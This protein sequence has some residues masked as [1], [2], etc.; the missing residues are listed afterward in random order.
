MLSLFASAAH[1]TILRALADGPVNLAALRGRAGIPSEAA[2]WG[3]IGNLI[4]IG[5]VE[6]RPPD[7]RPDLLDNELTPLGRELLSV[8]SAVDDWL[9]RGPAGPLEAESEP[10]R[11]AVKALVAGW[12]SSM[13]RALAARPLSLA[14]L[15]GL[16]ASLSGSSLERRLTA[17]CDA[18]LLISRDEDG[19]APAFAVTEWLREGV[20]PLLAA[21][22]CERLRLRTGTAPLMRL[23]VETLLLLAVPLLGPL[24]DGSCQIAVD[25]EDGSRSGPAGVRVEVREGGIVSCVS[26]LDDELGDAAFGSAEAWLEA[27]V[28]GAPAR[29]RIEGRDSLAALLIENL[30][31]RLY[32]AGP[33]AR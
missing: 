14:E 17:M 11:E 25:L 12:S 33:A 3:N 15:N 18:R 27:L 20:A 30:H 4:G 28:A 23:D 22:R 32:S 13:L 16:I 1:G 7:G 24:R 6:K 21:I 19:A 10:A 31:D 29:L 8:A 9:E 2:L 26:K 5:A